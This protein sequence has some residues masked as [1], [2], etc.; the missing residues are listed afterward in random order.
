V[1]RF[2]AESFVCHR[3]L[4]IWLFRSLRAL[5]SILNEIKLPSCLNGMRSSKQQHQQRE[6]KMEEYGG[7]GE[8]QFHEQ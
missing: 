5:T 3:L 8:K 1:H 2:N 4:F 7:D 6:M